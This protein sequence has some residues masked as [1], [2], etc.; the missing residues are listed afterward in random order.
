[1]NDS[2]ECAIEHYIGY[3]NSMEHANGIFYKTSIGFYRIFS[4]VLY[5]H[6]LKVYRITVTCFL[7]SSNACIVYCR[8]VRQLYYIHHKLRCRSFKFRSFTKHNDDSRSRDNV[9]HDHLCK[10]GVFLEL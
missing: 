1:M 10:V 5:F 3:V 8:K 4:I 2:Y 9:C 6:I 7:Q